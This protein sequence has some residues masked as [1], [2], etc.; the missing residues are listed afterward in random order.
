ML[1]VDKYNIITFNKGDD[2][3]LTLTLNCGSV[4]SPSQYELTEDDIIYFGIME[5]NQPFECALVRK[6][7]TKENLN[8]DKQ[9]II[10]LIGDDTYNIVPGEYCYEIKLKRVVD[11]SNYE[12]HTVVPKTRLIILE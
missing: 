7:F 10:K 1:T 9:V 12:I 11:E 3:E 5:A 2:I 8:S 6:V 4:M